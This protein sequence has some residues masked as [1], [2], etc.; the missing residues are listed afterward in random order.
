M[1]IKVLRTFSIIIYAMN[2]DLLFKAIRAQDMAIIAIELKEYTA[3][4]KAKE[5]RGS[6]P[7]LLTTYYGFI[8]IT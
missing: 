8:S 2:P 4:I 7:F 1:P 3:L 5:Q 6:T